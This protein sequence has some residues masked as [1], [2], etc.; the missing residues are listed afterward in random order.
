M[1]ASEI[2]NPAADMPNFVSIG[3]TI[4]AGFLGVNYAPFVVDQAGQLP[5]NVQALV[6]GPRS[7][8]RLELLREQDRDFGL[9][10]AGR[11]RFRARSPVRPR[12]AE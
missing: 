9:A 11:H 1:A 7:D 12:T 6:Q 2:G 4:G 5:T 10:G 8:R 3:S